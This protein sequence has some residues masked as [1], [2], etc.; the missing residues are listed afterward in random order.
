VPAPLLAVAGRFEQPVNIAG[1]RFLPLSL[2]PPLPLAGRVGEWGRGRGG[3]QLV[4][5][6]RRW[7]QT[8]QAV[9]SAANERPAVGWRRWGE[10]RFVQRC[11]DEG[12]DC[13]WRVVACDHRHRRIAQRLKRPVRPAGILRKRRGRGLVGPRRPEFYPLLESRNLA[14]GELLLGRHLNIAFVANGR[15]EQ[16]F[17]WIAGDN[18]RPRYATL[19][20]RFPRVQPQVRLLLFRAVARVAMF[21]QH[22]PNVGLE[23]VYCL[24]PL[25][26]RGGAS[27]QRH[28]QQPGSMQPQRKE[29]GVLDHGGSEYG[30]R[31][32]LP[33]KQSR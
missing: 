33:W 26:R 21:D 24:L 3:D 25:V 7:R 20:H 28:S 10:A 27:K 4:E 30:G 14:V 12:V 8:G 15:D 31:P 13:T 19:Q 1:V 2:S 18:R 9:R 16:A 6:V 23:V 11:A 32:A 29:G 17:S 5:V 22:R